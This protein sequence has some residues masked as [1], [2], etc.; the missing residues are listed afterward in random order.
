MAYDH[1]KSLRTLTDEQFSDGTTVD[2]SRIDDALEEAVEHFNS[3]PEGDVSTRF[4]KTQYVFGYQPAGF[5]GTPVA[6]TPTTFEAT[7]GTIEGP[8]FPWNYITNNEN[9]TAVTDAT[10]PSYGDASTPTAGFQNKWRIKG[11]NYHTNAAA[12]ALPV[13]N[14]GATGSSSWESDWTQTTAGAGAAG[15]AVRRNPANSYQLAWSHSW[16]FDDPVILDSVSAFLRTDLPSNLDSPPTGSF[17]Y[18]DA[19]FQFMDPTNNI[20]QSNNVSLHISVDNEFSKEERDL[21]DVEFIF[22]D[23]WLDGYEVNPHMTGGGNFAYEDM[24]PNSPDYN[25]GTSQGP[26]LQGRLIRFR[27]LNIP[28]RQ[29]ARVRFSVVVPWIGTQLG[30]SWPLS[31]YSQGLRTGNL[32]YKFNGWGAGAG[33]DRPEGTEP[34]YGFSMNGCM[35]VLEAVGR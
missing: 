13:S 10:G 15:T 8:L 24:L 33:D 19:P 22:Q 9:T 32:Q 30:L 17:G 14:E 26:G 16:I 34:V 23:R 27:D 31:R 3:I 2:G 25:T 20:N 1:K 12:F 18:Y 11:T 4:T 29:G 7:S 35:T 28:I 21:N 6:G 5:T